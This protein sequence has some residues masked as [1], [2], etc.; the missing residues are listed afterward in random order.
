MLAVT[1]ACLV[2]GLAVGVY[3]AFRFLPAL[4]S[5]REG[6]IAAWLVRVLVGCALAWAAVEIYNAVHSFVYL[7]KEANFGAGLGT[8]RAE[9]L[10][11][12][13]E[14]ILLVDSLLLGFAATVYLLAPARTV[15]RTPS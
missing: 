15:T 3:V 1:I 9:V 14:D 7:G 8:T 5:T 13:V 10:I 6:A 4:A 11:R 2:V 12:T